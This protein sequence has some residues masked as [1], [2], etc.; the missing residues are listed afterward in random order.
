MKKHLKRRTFILACL[1]AVL[2][3]GL[4]APA[5]IALPGIQ[6]EKVYAASYKTTNAAVNMRKS[7]DTKADVITVLPANVRVQYYDY[8]KG[9]YKVAYNGKIGWVYEEYFYGNTSNRP[10]YTP[11]ST[12]TPTTGDNIIGVY[13]MAE[14]LNL[15]S[16]MSTASSSNIIGLVPKGAQ[17][18]VIRNYSNQWYYIL[19]NGRTRGYIVGGH[20]T[21]D[22]SRMSNRSSST[23]TY[24]KSVTKVTKRWV[25]IRSAM[26]LKST[27]VIKRLPKG[28][29]LTVL[30]RKPR[31][32]YQVRWNGITCYV[33]GGY[34]TNNNYKE[35]TAYRLNL[36]SS[37]STSRDSNIIM[38]IPE[39]KKVVVK[40][41]WRNSRWLRVRYNGVTGY[42]KDGYFE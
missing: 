5:G 26:N 29:T 23:Q 6:A 32:W 14:S 13:T 31:N 19:Y 15:R 37:R 2:T 8:Q 4:I 1:I 39:G 34:F 30:D 28:T 40:K 22:T 17:V 25:K 7:Y 11:S 36:R 12:V 41:A 9:W 18:G 38:T 21:T 16:S 20:F 42:V 35:V 33:L 24:G 3:L 27:S 10:S